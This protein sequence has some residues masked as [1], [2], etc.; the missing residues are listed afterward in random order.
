M[1]LIKTILS[2]PTWR[3]NER[4]AAALGDRLCSRRLTPD[5]KS[6]NC[7]TLLSTFGSAASRALDAAAA[8]RSL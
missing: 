5:C 2:D 3:R 1:T 8:L 6:Y 4:G 7:P